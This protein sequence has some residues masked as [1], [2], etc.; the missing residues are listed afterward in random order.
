ML[1]ELV[2]LMTVS[3]PLILAIL[4]GSF[5]L[6]AIVMSLSW[7]KGATSRA[8]SQV[9]HFKAIYDREQIAIDSKNLML[10]LGLYVLHSRGCRPTMVLGF[11]LCWKCK[12]LLLLLFFHYLASLT[13][14]KTWE[15]FCIVVVF[16]QIRNMPDC[17]AFGHQ[18][19]V[20]EGSSL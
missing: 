9:F 12:S 13:L 5:N 16:V 4:H 8:G 19:C 20:L 2:P 18:F 17:E 11:G 3:Y 6:T 10:D 15:V 7:L 1:P 14:D